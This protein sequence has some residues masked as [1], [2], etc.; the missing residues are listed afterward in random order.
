MKFLRGK[1][2]FILVAFMAIFMATSF[3]GCG[4]S[5]DNYS[6]IWMGLDERGGAKAKLYQYEILPSDDGVTYTIRVTQFDYDINPSAQQAQWRESLP[7]F[8]N[9]YV[10]GK[11]NLIT[12]IGVIR[13][14]PG[15]FRLLYGNISLVRKAK[16]T[17]LKLKYVLRSNVEATYPGIAIAD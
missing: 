8:F 6:G 15:N 14:D 5:L 17:E 4:N 16:N 11:G 1:F 12:D 2:K 10:D 3:I 13:A 9:G 7:H